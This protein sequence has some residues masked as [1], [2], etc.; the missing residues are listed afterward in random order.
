ML[1]WGQLGCLI[2]VCQN[3]KWKNDKWA[4]WSKL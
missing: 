3:R 1:I 2:N 4:Y